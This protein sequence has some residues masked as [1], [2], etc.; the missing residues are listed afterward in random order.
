MNLSIYKPGQGYYTRVLSAIGAGML[1]LAGAV[2]LSNE[3]RA[4]QYQ[5]SDN[6]YYIDVFTSPRCR[7]CTCRWAWW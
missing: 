2:W 7:R 3:I 5:G 6:L 1:A 4:F